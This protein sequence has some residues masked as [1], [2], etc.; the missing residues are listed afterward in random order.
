[1][2][3]RAK[4]IEQVS[5]FAVVTG[6]CIAAGCALSAIAFPHYNVWQQEMAGRARL[7]EAEHSRRIAIEEAKALKE[8]AALKSE[9]EVIRAKGVA[10]ANKIISEEL[11]GP[12]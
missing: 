12:E 10:E 11:G 8:S 5:K 9:A 1:M 2:K 6:L 3:P 7:A 4:E